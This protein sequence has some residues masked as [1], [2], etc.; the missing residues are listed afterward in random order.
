MSQTSYFKPLRRKIGVMT[1]AMACVFAAG[2][3]RSLYS[4]E[5]IEW[6]FHSLVC[7]A[8]SCD[9][10]FLLAGFSDHEQRRGTIIPEV[11]S[12]EFRPFSELGS[13][14][15]WRWNLLSIRAGV[16]AQE[17]SWNSAPTHIAI[18]YP[19]IVIPLTLLSAYLLLS[20]PRAKKLP[21]KQG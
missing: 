7:G 14:I 16:F 4:L 3:V 21:E 2:W 1:L 10:T 5:M 13:R 20:R 19:W 17:L 9:Q 6:R 12:E 15:D 8:A 11:T 18:P